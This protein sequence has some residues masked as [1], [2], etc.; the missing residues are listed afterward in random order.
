MFNIGF[1][2]LILVLLVAFLVV[3]PKDLPRV[4]RWLGR[5][6]KKLRGFIREVKKETGW[7]EIEKDFKDSKAEVD[8]T[9][10][11][12]KKDMD[13]SPELKDASAEWDRTVKSVKDELDQTEKQARDGINGA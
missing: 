3:G 10:R 9:V 13:I 8:Q 7:D 11:G 2:E 1:S 12:L 5:T 6:V 4:A